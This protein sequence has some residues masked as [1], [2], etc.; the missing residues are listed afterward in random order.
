M[1]K[2]RITSFLT[3]TAVLLPTLALAQAPARGAVQEACKSEMASLCASAGNGGGAVFRCLADNQA[4]LGADCSAALK[5]AQDRRAAFQAACK[6]D[7]D[8]LCAESGNGRGG[9]V[10]A[11]LRS[12]SADLSKPCADMLASMP[13]RN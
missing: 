2:I 9:E 3:L 1:V 10:V 4:K 13:S 11:C 5:T 7:T 6:A 8:K 12:K